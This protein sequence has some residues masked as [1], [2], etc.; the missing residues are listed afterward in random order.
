MTTMM[1]SR[2]CPYTCSF[3]DVPSN[4]GKKHRH[5]SPENVVEEVLFHQQAS[6]INNF[7]FKDSIFNLRKNDTIGFCELLLEKNININWVCNSRVDTLDADLVQIM[8]KAGCKVINFGVESMSTDVLKLMNK[9]NSIEMVS[10][11][12]KMCRD[13]KIA[14]TAYY[15]VGNEGETMDSYFEGLDQLIAENPTLA[16][17]SIS[18]AYPGTEH[19]YKAVQAGVLKDPEWYNCFEKADST[20]GYSELLGFT[21]EEQRQAAKNSTAR[22]F[23]RPLKMLEIL[24]HF[25]SLQFLVLGLRFLWRKNNHIEY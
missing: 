8:A 12:F 7:S 17:F 13:V 4:M 20:G 5:R 10:K 23:F 18:T 3:C 25:F 6:G 22:F 15:M 2:G 1:A 24:R 19:Y 16:G 21:I 9:K 14:T 11:S